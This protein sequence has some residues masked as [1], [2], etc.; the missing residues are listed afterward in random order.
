MLVRQTGPMIWDDQELSKDDIGKTNAHA[1]EHGSHP[2]IAIELGLAASFNHLV[3]FAF[4]FQKF[5]FDELDLFL[6]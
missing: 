1:L 2:E 4:F 3:D 6:W 5:Q